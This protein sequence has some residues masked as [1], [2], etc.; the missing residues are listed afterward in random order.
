MKPVPVALLLALAA[1]AAPALADELEGAILAYDRVANVI[2][3]SDKS[4]VP[5]ESF[6][7][8]LPADLVAGD[9]VSIVYRSDEDAGI[10]AVESVERVD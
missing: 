8:E 10:N 3:M 6:T 4:V 5:L 9:R 1:A 2:V 7:G